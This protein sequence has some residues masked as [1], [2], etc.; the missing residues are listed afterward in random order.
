MT[1]DA[2][3]SDIITDLR[4]GEV[5][6]LDKATL[7]ID[8]WSGINKTD[9]SAR[10]PEIT[11]GDDTTLYSSNLREAY[12]QKTNNNYLLVVEKESGWK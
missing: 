7:N 8:K 3:S 11:S 10:P 1:A 4:I 2:A 9:E 5:I 6:L 12:I